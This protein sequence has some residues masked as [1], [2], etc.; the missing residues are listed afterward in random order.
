MSRKIGS[1]KLKKSPIKRCTKKADS[2]DEDLF[3]SMEICEYSYEKT[4]IEILNKG[5]DQIDIIFHLSDIHIHNNERREEYIMVIDIACIELIKRINGMKNAL[6]VITGDILENRSVISGSGIDIMDYLFDKLSEIAPTIIIPVNH[7]CNMN[8]VEEINI[9][10]SMIK[11]KQKNIYYLAKTGAYQ[12]NNII[13]GVTDVRSEEIFDISEIN[14]DQ[15]DTSKYKDWNVIALY[16]GTIKSSI[17]CNGHNMRSKITIDMFDGYDFVML[18]DIHQH[19]YLDEMKRI[20]YAGSFIQQNYGEPLDGHGIIEWNLVD[21]T[22]KLLNIKNDYGFVVIRVDYG[23]IINR[24]KIPL[25]PKIQI[26]SSNTDKSIIDKMIME[27]SIEHNLVDI[28]HVPLDVSKNNNSV[29]VEERQDIS[30]IECQIKYITEYLDGEDLKGITVDDIIVFHKKIDN[31]NKSKDNHFSCGQRWALKELCFMNMFCFEDDK[32]NIINLSQYDDSNLIKGI[33]ADN[34]HGK[35]AILDIILYCLFDKFSRGKLPRDIM[36]NNKDN[37]KCSLL[38]SVGNK[39]YIVE[40]Q[41]QTVRT[42]ITVTAM[43]YEIISKDGKQIKKS[44]A[45]DIDDGKNSEPKNSQ[46]SKNNCSTKESK[47]GGD[48]LTTNDIIC[49]LVGS[50]DDFV[51]TCIHLQNDFNVFIDNTPI[52]KNKKICDMLKLNIFENYK[53]K[54]SARLRNINSLINNCN[55]TMTT[56]L[57]KKSKETCIESMNIIE[58]EINNLKD[59]KRDII[60]TFKKPSTPKYPIDLVEYNFESSGD[61]TKEICRLQK[62]IQSNQNIDYD[63]YQ[64]KLRKCEQML[65]EIESK[66]SVNDIDD[67][68][69]EY[70]NKS[71][72][73]LAKL[74]HNFTEIIPDNV[75]SDHKDKMKKYLSKKTKIEGKVIKKYGKNFN[76]DN[77][78]RDLGYDKKN[79]EKCIVS[80]TH[81]SK[82]QL[83]TTIKQNNIEIKELN[84]E[85]FELIENNCQ[86]NETDRLVKEHEKKCNIAFIKKIN[87]ITSS[88]SNISTNNNIISDKIANVI[89][90]NHAYVSE[91]KNTNKDITNILSLENNSDEQEKVKE[92]IALI[93]AEN[94]DCRKCIEQFN[95][96]EELT[97]KIEHLNVKI[98]LYEKYV[99]LN[100]KY[101]KI[102]QLIQNYEYNNQM[103]SH[104]NIINQKITVVEDIISDIDHAKKQIKKLRDKIDDYKLKLTGVTNYKSTLKSLKKF[105]IPFTEWEINDSKYDKSIERLAVIRNSIENKISQFGEIEEKINIYDHHDKEK[106]S[107]EQELEICKLYIDMLQPKNLPNSIVQNY[108][109]I[110][111]RHVN[112]TL[113]SCTN[114][115]IIMSTYKDLIYKK[116]NKKKSDG[117]VMI[118]L[119]RNDKRTHIVMTSGYEKF[120]VNLCIRIALRDILH[121][122][123]PNFCII[124]EGWV[125]S[126]KKNLSKI[127]TVLEFLKNQYDHV[128][129]ISHLVE[130]KLKIDIPIIIHRDESKNISYVNNTI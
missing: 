100:N 29:K 69:T 1:N 122:G 111:E 108:L 129:L 43:L 78:I 83:L 45:H 3:E 73:L 62:L 71:K 64:Q 99:T 61:I 37:M 55:T 14:F 22:S 126:D 127:S 90:I 5:D 54:A 91:L 89:N 10:T 104:N 85:L 103:V 110:I 42:K 7:D 48:R 76:I 113:Q 106:Q 38:F 19:Q 58:S 24:V 115:G 125:C 21:K 51:S 97:D 8:N 2:S 57:N 31:D 87:N 92:K 15:L 124:D 119:V 13:F 26:V 16:H 34:Y 114:F 112:N 35:S 53:K 47:T 66:Y 30:N 56:I 84:E 27:L 118:Y 123:K 28:F 9:I 50:Y 46:L 75:L 128:I 82:Q 63:N 109:P 65:L 59:E 32:V 6:I 20:A 41:A 79:L 52:E 130:L 25:H 94:D 101:T 107:L 120:M 17:A 12:Y 4:L 18:G 121:L 60:F 81:L 23:K 33:I 96:N 77:I 105:I 117:V 68:L 49:Q 11:K 44:L 102:D 93:V 88:L 40:K 98:N 67:Q 74:V 80:F 72:K 70:N 116:K 36:N 39:T 95:T 86:I